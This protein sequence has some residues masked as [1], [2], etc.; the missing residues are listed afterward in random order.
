[1]PT[2]RTWAELDDEAAATLDRVVAEQRFF[3]WEIEFPD[4]FGPE[5]AG[6][7]A[8]LGNPPWE[9]VQA[10][11]NEFFSR[12]DPLYRTYGKTEALDVQ[13]RLFVEIPGLE[14]RW[15]ATT[16]RLQVDVT[17]FVKA[18]ADPFDAVART[19]RSA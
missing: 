8:V 10:E 5:R 15:D 7:D 6:F 12:H 16:R 17:N 14:E 9:T 13:R 3:H 2:P 1:M 11:P 18:L 4:V 19:R